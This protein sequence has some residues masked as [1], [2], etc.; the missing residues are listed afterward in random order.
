MFVRATYDRDRKTVHY[1]DQDG[2]E[3]LYIGGSFAWRT[4]NPGNLT[5]PG[6]YVMD[7]A[8]GYAARTSD[9]RTLFVIFRDRVAGARRHRALLKEIYGDKSVRGMI[10]A[11]APPTENNTEEYIDFV[12]NKAG[13]SPGDII[14]SLSEDKFDALADAMEQKEGN[15]PGTIRY[16]GKPV[17]VQLRDKLNQPFSVQNFQIK[18]GETSIGVRSNDAG[19]LPLIYNGLLGREISFYYNREAGEL[20]KMGSFPASTKSSAF[21][22]NAPYFLLSSRSRVHQVDAVSRP[23]MHIVRAGETLSVIARKYS[24]TVD[25]MVQ[26]NSL[27]NKD[28]IYARQ[29]LRIPS[30]VPSSSQAADGGT[31]AHPNVPTDS[32]STHASGAFSPGHAAAPHSSG[33]GHHAP[34]AVHHERMDEQH[35]VTLIS[36]SALEPSGP[37]WCGRFLQSRSLDDLVEPFRSNARRFTQAMRDAGITVRISTTYRPIER[38]YLMYYAAAIARGNLAP[39]SVPAWAGVNIDWAHRDQSGAPD[40]T[41]AKA[42][43]RDMVHGY[44]IGSNPVG[45]PRNS[46]HNTRQAVDMTLSFYIGKNVLDAS[47]SAITVHSFRDLKIIGESYSV[48]HK[49]DN[50]PPHWSVTGR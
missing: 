19:E 43:A 11:Y 30:D 25:A 35:P 15:F 4:N 10:T 6:K 1:I 33:P 20:E 45:R 31:A 44:Q 26:E 13:V 23:R 32:G 49:L 40:S 9:S 29:H 21:T 46:N 37:Q 3:T 2:N 14:G 47:G 12:K 34:I 16:L 8:I 22:F 36:S 17:Q 5:K 38:S 7:D 24:V 18:S 27:K 39:E 42:A 50:D 41:R 48:H 28:H